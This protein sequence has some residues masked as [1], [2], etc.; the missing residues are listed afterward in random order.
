VRANVIDGEELALLPEKGDQLSIDGHGPAFAVDKVIG[1]THGLELTH[2][3]LFDKNRWTGAPAPGM[4][5][6]TVQLSRRAVMS[7]EVEMKFPVADLRA[8]ENRLRALNCQPHDSVVEVDEYYNAPDRDFA[9]T[10]EALRIRWIGEACR[11][12]YKGP[13]RDLETKTRTE[14]ELALPDGKESASTCSE[15]LTHLGYRPVAIVSKQRRTYHLQ[16][17][18]FVLEIC[19][20]D[21]A[22]VGQFIELECV[23][24]ESQLAEARSAVLALAQ[25]LGLKESERRSYLEMLLTTRKEVNA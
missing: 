20:D 4:I 1:P 24:S 18:A 10:D 23:T 9:S 11:I 12:T 5:H 17:G 15:L 21:V 6:F 14:I 25:E 19:L 22:G 13:K 8:L 2:A 7:V 16:R 3:F